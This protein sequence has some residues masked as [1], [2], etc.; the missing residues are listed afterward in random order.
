ML[1]QD[2]L[3]EVENNNH[4]H[5]QNNLETFSFNDNQHSLINFYPNPVVDFITLK[6]DF[7]NNE[8]YLILNNLG[9]IVLDGEIRNN[10]EI[11]NLSNLSS[12]IY[13]LK[14]KNNT[15]KIIKK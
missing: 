3:K 12:G 6:S 7:N 1:V 11:I 9:Q 10:L 2:I 15:V 13:V 14:V 4:Y 5:Q 8:K